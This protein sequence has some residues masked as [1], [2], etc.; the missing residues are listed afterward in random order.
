MFMRQPAENGR[1]LYALASWQPA[2]LR[3]CW[4]F[5]AGWFRDARSQPYDDPRADVLSGDGGPGL[6]IFLDHA[7]YE[8]I[9]ACCLCP[10][11]P[12]LVEQAQ[13]T[14][15][16]EYMPRQMRSGIVSSLAGYLSTC[17]ETGGDQRREVCL[18]NRYRTP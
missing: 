6:A 2:T 7:M 11:V 14:T 4:N 18:K 16:A 1:R 5:R 3:T 12:T 17:L 8:W 13:V 10:P 15:T 9:E